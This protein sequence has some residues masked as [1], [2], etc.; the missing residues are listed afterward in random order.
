VTLSQRRFTGLIS[1]SVVESSTR[2]RFAWE[3]LRNQVLRGV[4]SP[5]SMLRDSQWS[6]RDLPAAEHDGDRRTFVRDLTL[7]HAFGV[8]AG[9]IMESSDNIVLS[10]WHDPEMRQWQNDAGSYSRTPDRGRSPRNAPRAATESEQSEPKTRFGKINPRRS[11]RGRIRTGS[12]RVLLTHGNLDCRSAV[13]DVAEDLDRATP[14]Q[15]VGQLDIELVYADHA[16]GESGK[17]HVGRTCVRAHI[18]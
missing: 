2:I 14:R 7:S 6:F 18:V 9:N 13:A 16:R 15:E 4:D 12:I 8:G 17:Q 5:T 11:H 1:R 3:S 10:E